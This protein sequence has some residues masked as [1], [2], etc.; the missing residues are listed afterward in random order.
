MIPIYIPTLGRDR[1]ITMEGLSPAL[2]PYITIVTNKAQAATLH[3]QYSGAAV[4]I[5]PHQ[6]EPGEKPDGITKGIS[7]VRQWIT[8]YC[9]EKA[10]HSQCIM[11]DDDLTF[12]IRISEDDWHLRLATHGE[13]GELFV[14][15]QDQLISNAMVGVSARQ[16]NNRR[17]ETIQHCQRMWAVW[18]IDIEVMRRL[19]LKFTAVPTMQDFWMQMGFLTNGHRTAMICDYAHNQ[20]ASNAKGGCSLFRTPET[21]RV[22]IAALEKA[23]PG[24]IKSRLAK[25]KDGWFG[26][27]DPRADVTFYGKKAYEFGLQQSIL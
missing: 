4:V 14:E 3:R 1:L 22:S 6:A 23:Y 11:L 27:G 5:C 20:P 21:Q 10:G 18:S 19:K 8:D 16:G 7:P 9:W 24:F 25:T 26:T 15:M 2:H 17:T 13:V 12:Y